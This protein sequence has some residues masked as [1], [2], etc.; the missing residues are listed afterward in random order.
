MKLVIVKWEDC[1]ASVSGP[2]FPDQLL[3]PIIGVTVGH[4]IKE[5]DDG[6][7]Y[8]GLDRFEK[9]PMDPDHSYR[10]IAIIPKR[11]IIDYVVFDAPE[12]AA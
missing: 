10:W 11:Q 4:L 8:I 9:D 5:D 2:Y 1:R 12:L 7:I 6:A 3:P